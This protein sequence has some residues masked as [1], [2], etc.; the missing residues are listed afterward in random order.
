[1]RVVE[2]GADEVLGSRIGADHQS[3]G[4][5]EELRLS[6]RAGGPVDSRDR[7][8]R[9]RRAVDTERAESMGVGEAI[10]DL[11]VGVLERLAL[12]DEQF[13][14]SFRT[15]SAAWGRREFQRTGLERGLAYPWERRAPQVVRGLLIESRGAGEL[16]S[17]P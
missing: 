16:D 12:D 13:V 4:D 14:A 3:R 17:P 2:D 5:I 7:R 6:Q 15:L 9:D 8:E 10:V 11:E 1:L